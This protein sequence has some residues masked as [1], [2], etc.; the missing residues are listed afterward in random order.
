VVVLEL[1]LTKV[2]VVLVV[3]AVVLHILQVLEE[4]QLQVKEMLVVA[5]ALVRLPILR[6]VAVALEA[7]AVTVQMF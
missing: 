7:P 2:L 5:V 1:V 6:V 3:R 4:P